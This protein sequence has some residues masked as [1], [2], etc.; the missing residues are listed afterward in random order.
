VIQIIARICE[1]M[2]VTASHVGEYK[3]KRVPVIIKSKIRR[4]GFI[5]VSTS[6]T[7]IL[8]V[9]DDGERASTITRSVTAQLRDS[10]NRKVCTYENIRDAQTGKR[11]DEAYRKA[12]QIHGSTM[13][14]VSG[15]RRL[16]NVPGCRMAS[17][18]YGR[19]LF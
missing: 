18:Y 2:N 13:T 19:G 6:E 4:T 8:F 10:A 17:P 9:S 7:G 12:L 1:I 15:D 5:Y 3:T 11:L 14:R 16:V